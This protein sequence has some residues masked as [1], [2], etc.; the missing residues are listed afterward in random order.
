MNTPSMAQLK[1]Q[2]EQM[3]SLTIQRISNSKSDSLY[4]LV[5][6]SGI[7]YV[8]KDGSHIVQGALYNLAD[9]LVNDTEAS[10][11]QWRTV[12][13]DAFSESTINFSASDEQ[14]IVTVF[15]GYYLWVLPQTA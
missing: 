14:H 2:I 11:R 6:D 7:L 8:T 9:N 13:L 15:T 12:E 1:Q 3:T 10:M 5:T 4:E